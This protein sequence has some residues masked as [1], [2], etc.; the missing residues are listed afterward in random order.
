MAMIKLFPIEEICYD[1]GD[2]DV[3]AIGVG[4]LFFLVADLLGA[5]LVERGVAKRRE[6]SFGAE[7][8]LELLVIDLHCAIKLISLIII[9]LE[10]HWNSHA[11][12]SI[13]HNRGIDIIYALT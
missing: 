6:G 1:L 13:E 9:N 7:L 10:C 4:G 2:P 8:D 11:M 3:I 5:S 12:I